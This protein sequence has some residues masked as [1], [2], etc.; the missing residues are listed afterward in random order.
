MENVKFW[1]LF[2]IFISIVLLAIVLFYVAGPFL[3]SEF[4]RV[5]FRL[6]R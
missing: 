2:L 1:A 6:I 4:V 3:T 5:V